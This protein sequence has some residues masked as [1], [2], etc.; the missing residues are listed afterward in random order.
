MYMCL[1]LSSGL[2]IVVLPIYSRDV[3][4]GGSETFGLL[5]SAWTAGELV[6]LLGVG[7]IGWRWPLGRSIAVATFI[8]GLVLALWSFRPSMVPLALILAGAGIT[9]SSLTAWAQTI[10]M[11]LIPP[12]LR[13]RVFALLRTFMQSTR[14]IGS[15]VA[16][17]LLTG[18]DLTP[19]LAAI[20]IL[21]VVPGAIGI[22]LPALG[23]GPTAEPEVN[24]ASPSVVPP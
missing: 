12:E 18:G 22:W 6:G 23:R 5:L 21:V 4:A 8:S 16:G 7:A 24:R 10:R 3:L 20:A 1:N 14:P 2:T 19:A 17:W 15:I 9:S 13:G 11:R